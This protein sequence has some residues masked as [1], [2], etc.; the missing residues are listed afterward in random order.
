MKTAPIAL[1]FSAQNSF[2]LEYIAKWI[3]EEQFGFNLQVTNSL[4]VYQQTIADLKINYSDNILKADITFA[5]VNLL[6]E[7][8]IDHAIP[9][10]ELYF[11]QPIFFATKE[12]NA[13]PFD[14]MAASFWLISRYEEYATKQKDVHNRFL[15]VDSLAYKNGFLRTPI[16]EVWVEEFKLH[17]LSTKPH[18]KFKN[19]KFRVLP[20]IDVDSAYAF[21]EKGVMRSTGA[22]FKDILSADWS[23]LAFRMNVLLGRRAD[24]FDTYETILNCHKS[25]YSRPVFFFLLGDYDVND[26]NVPAN[27]RRLQQLIKH[28][29]DYATIGLHPSYASFGDY[30]KLSIEANRLA[31]ITHSDVKHSRQ[32]FLMLKFP[33]TYRGLMELEI[34]NDYTMG[35][36]TH[37]GFR[38]GTSESFNFFD[39][40][41]NKE[42][43]LRVHPFC[44]ME[45]TYKY[46]GSD[47][48]EEAFE[49]AIE[50]IATLKNV[51]GKFCSLWHNDSLSNY[52]PWQGWQDLYLRV[53]NAAK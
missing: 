38:A 3:F 8:G 47:N 23:Q 12:H 40:L 25:D 13:Y 44:F 36:A 39:L 41:Q 5:P 19:K 9:E 10:V 6:F 15:A 37:S 28:I 16:I 24:P 52:K 21:L 45:A 51:N 33:E 29:S 22:L 18:L 20:T 4:Q 1:I 46:Y 30:E 14:L 43:H 26:K 27:S 42:T 35:Y 32:H 48:V 31:E 2:R 7:K 49:N 17:L 34:D 50:L 11:N 53:C